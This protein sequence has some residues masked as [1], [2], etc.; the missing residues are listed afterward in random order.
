MSARPRATR[1]ADRDPFQASRSPDLDELVDRS[2]GA[3]A[4]LTR[5]AEAET[6]G[7]RTVTKPGLDVDSWLAIE[8]LLQR[9]YHDLLT[10]EQALGNLRADAARRVGAK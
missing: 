2:K 1:R 3:V 7:N 4:M 9:T 8:A 10:L 6:R 5:F